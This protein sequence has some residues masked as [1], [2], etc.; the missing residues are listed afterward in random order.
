MP[1]GRR[2]SGRNAA[3]GSDTDGRLADLVARHVNDLVDAVRNEVRRNVADEVRA[4]LTGVRLDEPARGGRR[5]AGRTARRKI[6]NCIAPGCPN[7]SK[8]P[9][10][11]YLCEKHKDAPK[12]DYEAW[13]KAQKDQKL[14]KAK[15]AKQARAAA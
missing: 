10:F 8:G 7:P 14:K 11:H 1:R 12:K 3:R 2:A 5:L 9:R 4:F 15:G 13:R 6:V